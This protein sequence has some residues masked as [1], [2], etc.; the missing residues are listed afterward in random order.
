MGIKQS[1]NY[2]MFHRFLL[3]LTC[4]SLLLGVTTLSLS[5][6]PCAD[7]QPTIAGAQI[8]CNNQA[9]V[10][11]STPNIPGHTYSWS[12]TSGAI[13]SG[14]NTNQVGVTWGPVGAGS[15][16][17][18]E[19]N[20]SIPCFTTVTKSIKIQPLLISYFYYTDTTCY[21]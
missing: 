11:Y 13:V 19:T 2:N 12:V 16:S 10:I 6:Q 17:V 18:T 9:G 14:A 4:S 3:Y 21:G 15:L 20:P 7:T 8:V 1:N 5:A